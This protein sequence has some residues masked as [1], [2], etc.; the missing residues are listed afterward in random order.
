MT[1]LCTCL[2]ALISLSDPQITISNSKI[3]V[4]SENSYS[5][6]LKKSIIT[7]VATR[8][9]EEIAILGS[10]QKTGSG[11]EF[12]PRFPFETATDYRVRLISESAET[13]LEKVVSL[14]KLK[15]QP[16]KVTH[17]YPSADNL[18]ENLLR[19]YIHF[20]Q[21]MKVGDAYPNLKLLDS[22]GK[23]LDRPFLELDEELWS[24]DGKRFTLLLDPGR[25]K[26]ELKP[27]EEMGPVL[28]DGKTYTL[29]IGRQWKT[30]AGDFLKEEFRK[31]FSTLPRI[32]D[33]LDE[34]KWKVVTPNAATKEPVSLGFDHS[35]DH[36]ML[37]RVIQVVDSQGREVAGEIQIADREKRWSLI[38]KSSW[39]AGEYQILV[40][41]V[42]ED[43]CG[44]SLAAG[45]E[46]R[47]S[48]KRRN[49]G[50]IIKLNFTV[51]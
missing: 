40:R 23:A 31:K 28:E 25:V 8:P 34:K 19:F 35:L 2:F 14:P 10:W 46:I 36:G 20:D 42:L 7:V 45:F 49:R 38:P 17:V 1:A 13:K 4:T 12:N 27:H 44:N 48:E 33:R 32:E 16:A 5:L 51:K 15:T 26:R 29:V 11:Y 30:Q 9:E 21:P 41:D 24:P 37:E 43:S 50:Q 18:P 6:D 3:A 47:L 22:A 39:A